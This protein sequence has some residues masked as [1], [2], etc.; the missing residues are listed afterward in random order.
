MDNNIRAKTIVRIL[1]TFFGIGYS[2]I[3]PG[4]LASL[5]GFFI[6]LIFIRGV[7][8]LHLAFIIVFTLLGFCV[9]TKAENIFGK[10]DARQIVID[11]L[12][13]MLVG[14]LFLPFDIRVCVLGFF[15]FRI[16]DGLKPYPIYKI[17]KLHGSYGIMMDDLIAGL[18]TNITLQLFLKFS[19]F[20]FS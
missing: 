11:D 13:G 17:E 12:T 19:S 14:V 15:I 16:M 18:Y 20:N 4:T 5:A 8:A 10:K 2:P 6:Y 9:C 1:S 7:F 3:V